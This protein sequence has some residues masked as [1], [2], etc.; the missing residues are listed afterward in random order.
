[1][2]SSTSSSETASS[3]AAL[4]ARAIV[5]RPGFVRLTASDR[6]GVAQPV[7]EREIPQRPWPAMLATAALIFCLALG[8][9]E[10]R[11]RAI[12]LAAGD[13][14]DSPS[15]WAE[16][17]RRLD[18][19]G[20]QV[21]I[22]GDSRI[23]FGTDLDRYERVTGVRPVQLALPGT[24]GRYLLENVAHHSSFDG[25]LIVGISEV[26]YF[27]NPPGRATDALA[28]YAFESP[29]QWS[30]QQL[31]VMLSRELAFLDDNY[32]LSK[33]VRRLD[34]G[35]RAGARG[36][37]GR[38]WKLYTMTDDRQ[39]RM[40]APIERPGFLQDH[41]R[42]AWFA[43][44]PRKLDDAVIASTQRIT[45]EAVAAIR[46]RGGEV[47][48]LRP[49]A[50]GPLH[51]KQVAALPRA[52]GWDP[53]LRDAGVQGVYFDDE[54]AMR[55]LAIP[56]YSHVSA[57]CATVYT[58]AYARALARLTPRVSVRADA[59]PPLSPADCADR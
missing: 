2:P 30:G 8:V 29:S 44:P 24:N 16:Q 49:P 33:L 58:D 48:F 46:A 40:W 32:R 1:M 31:Y 51:E 36:E 43:A 55:G 41:A 57:A 13:L 35:W 22:V 23:L 20:V 7:P 54:P 59:P 19:G 56:E 42:Y 12:G 21:A 27:G 25:L 39:A 9:W 53:L 6:P 14:G 45:R 38:P 3:E 4:D 34:H 50:S 26:H 47:V 5:D 15:G 11:M 10:W 37:Y 17:R 28:R 52:R 18:A